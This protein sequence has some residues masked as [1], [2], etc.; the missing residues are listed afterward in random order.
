M[1]CLY[2]LFRLTVNT[3]NKFKF[4]KMNCSVEGWSLSSVSQ[5]Q[6]WRLPGADLLRAVWSSEGYFAA[7]TWPH[8][9]GGDGQAHPARGPNCPGKPL[10]TSHPARSHEGWFSES[11]ILK[12][13]LEPTSTHILPNSWCKE[14]KYSKC[15][16]NKPITMSV[17]RTQ[18][19]QRKYFALAP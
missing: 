5:E 13:D 10:I 9:G 7:V 3:S 1:Y 18:K 15:P 2:I 6:L 19:T 16:A 4:W 11:H 12:L 17:I 14:I 8:A